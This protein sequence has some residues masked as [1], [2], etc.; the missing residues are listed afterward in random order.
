MYTQEEIALA[1][2]RY[3]VAEARENFADLLR[4]AEDGRVLEITRHGRPVAVLVSA[5]EYAKLTG[6]A[7]SYADAV[8]AFR[9]RVREEDL[10][11]SDAFEDLR[12]PSPG[13]PASE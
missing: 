3:S 9:S 4:R 5:R 8:A 12:D 11:P 2:Q 7:G 6:A 10:L 13:R 1:S